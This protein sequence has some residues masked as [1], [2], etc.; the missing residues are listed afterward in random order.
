MTLKEIAGRAALKAA[1]KVSK[2]KTFQ[3]LYKKGEKFVKKHKGALRKI[4]QGIAK[5]ADK[6]QTAGEISEAAAPLTGA[7]AP[8]VAAAGG[9][10]YGAATAAKVGRQAYR[11][12][13]D[14]YKKQRKSP[15][16]PIRDTVSYAS[17]DVGYKPEGQSIVHI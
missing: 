13:M 7:A 11:S 8:F 16:P 14:A 9:A 5:Y 17:K 1:K 15:P 10:L 3:A 4:D 12:A 2:T 6:A